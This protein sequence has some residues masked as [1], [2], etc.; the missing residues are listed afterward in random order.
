M[1]SPR[2][3][4]TPSRRR[5]DWLVVIGPRDDGFKTSLKARIPV[6]H[7]TWEPTLRAWLVHQDARAELERV[8]AEHS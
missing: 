8:I 7:R 6:G 5:P 1:V 3:R 2:W 4:I